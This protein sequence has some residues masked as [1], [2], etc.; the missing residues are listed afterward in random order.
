MT[1]RLVM[2]VWETQKTGTEIAMSQFV[3]LAT[4]MTHLLENIPMPSLFL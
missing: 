1:D 4:L 2:G 3:S